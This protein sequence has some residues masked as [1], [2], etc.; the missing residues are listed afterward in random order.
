MGVTVVDIE[1]M[2]WRDVPPSPAG[3]G[4]VRV[5]PFATGCESIPA[6]QLVEYEPGR[7]ER[8]H[9]HAEDE[10]FYVLEGAVTVD[11]TVARSGA[12]VVIEAGTTYELTS[13]HGCRFLRL[14]LRGPDP[15]IGKGRNADREPV[16]PQPR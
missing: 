1:A 2:D 15:E 6:G 10:V 9:S 13:E 5:K 12:V 3:T 14:R 4:D 7:N 8:P 11:G 16:S